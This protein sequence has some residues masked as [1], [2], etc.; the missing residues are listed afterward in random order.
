LVA[1]VFKRLPNICFQDGNQSLIPRWH[2]AIWFQ[3]CPQYLI[4]NGCSSLVI[5][6][7]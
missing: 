7:W 1:N 3:N 5:L 6:L 2:L 4:L